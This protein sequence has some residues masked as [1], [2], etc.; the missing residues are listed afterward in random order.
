M[1]GP[2]ELHALLNF[3][4]LVVMALKG[5]RDRGPCGSTPLGEASGSWSL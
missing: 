3:K 4:I 2:R 5:H 1:V